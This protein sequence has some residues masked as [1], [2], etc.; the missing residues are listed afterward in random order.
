MPPEPYWCKE[1]PNVPRVWSAS[2]LRTF[3][4]C[5]RKFELQYVEGWT[6]RG[7]GNLDFLFGQTVHYGLFHLID[8][9]C[10]D[11]QR[12][13]DAALDHAIYKA[14]NLQ[15]LPPPIRQTQAGKTYL[16]VVRSLVWYADQ[17]NLQREAD[18]ILWIANKP[19]L[20]LPFRFNLPRISPDGEPY[21]VRGYID[22][23]RR[24]ALGH[25]VWDYKT[26]KT[27]ITDWYLAK[28][29]LDIQNTIYSAGVMTL[30]AE[31]F[32]EFWVDVLG[33]GPQVINFSRNSYPL[34]E[35]N[36]NENL[37]DVDELIHRAEIYAEREYYPKNTTACTFCDFR[38]A[39]KSK[40]NVRFLKLSSDFVERRREFVDTRGETQ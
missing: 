20:E 16:G 13:V 32:T 14:V 33:V 24:T 37:R 31:P 3:Q 30:T 4:E 35:E 27:S 18:Q 5:P 25:A 22:A 26:T 19:A 36:L 12:D 17:Y 38:D 28:F 39:C 21:S 8:T 29:E 1:A 34:H 9:L 2:S 40:P 11:P 6:P 10:R 15:D 23:L 7:V